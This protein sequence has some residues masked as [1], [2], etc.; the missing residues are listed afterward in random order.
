MSKE[1]VKEEILQYTWL[2]R[3]DGFTAL[4]HEI[5][6]RDLCSGCGACSAVCP[7]NVVDVDDFPRLTGKCT[8]CGYCLI[9]CPRS[10]LPLNEVEEELFGSSGE[11]LGNYEAIRSVK[12]LTG[13]GQDGGFVT[14]LLC[15]LLDNKIVDGAIVSGVDKEVPWKA[16]AVLTTKSKEIRTAAGSRYTNSPNLM[17][18]KEAKEKDLK[19]LAVVGLPCQIQG[20][21]KLGYHSIEGVDLAERVKFTIAIFCSKNFLS[22]MLEE[23]VVKKHSLNL[24]KITKFDIK[25]KNLLAYEGRKK[26]EIPLTELKDYA[27]NGCEVCT[28]FTGKLAEFSVGAVG[29]PNGFSTVLARTDEASKI[30]DEMETVKLVETR[31]VEEG[32]SGLGAI[33]RSAAKKESN[34]KKNVW[35]R[36][37][38]ELPLPFKFMEF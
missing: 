21:R 28:D 26:T 23:V 35:K 11:L 31:D 38:A 17:A 13:K 15:Y 36:I 25:G 27:R 7:E 4:E 8:Y 37:Q 34:T 29:S 10:F 12:S 5:I 19:N 32:K 9:Q 30:L 1:S 18:L 6:Y 16:R 24:K 3:E 22:R 33:Q 20:V 14:T 2:G